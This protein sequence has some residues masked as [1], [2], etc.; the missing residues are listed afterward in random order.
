MIRALRKNLMKGKICTTDRKD[1][2][3]NVLMTIIFHHIGN[4]I[5]IETACLELADILFILYLHMGDTN[6]IQFI[7][8]L[9]MEEWLS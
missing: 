8:F 5:V 9:V 3:Q 4:R 6:R 1:R 7:T 2:I